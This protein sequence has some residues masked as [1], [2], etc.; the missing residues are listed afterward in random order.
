MRTL[1]GADQYE[2]MGALGFQNY[3]QLLKLQAVIMTS[4]I[5]KYR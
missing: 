4:E 3:S 1:T 2:H 5:L